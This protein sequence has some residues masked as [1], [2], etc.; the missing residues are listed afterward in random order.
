MWDR[1]NENALIVQ[2]QFAREI[3]DAR[4]L[5]YFGENTTELLQQFWLAYVQNSF[6]TA[7]NPDLGFRSM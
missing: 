7:M 3:F 6:E 5:L 4:R 2:L 1:T